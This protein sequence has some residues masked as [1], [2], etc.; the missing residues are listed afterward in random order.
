MFTRVTPY[1]P[2]KIIRVELKQ[3]RYVGGRN[4]REKYWDLS[5][6]ST[7]FRNV[8]LVTSL[9][10]SP[11]FLPNQLRPRVRTAAGA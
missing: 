6:L 9:E 4:S 3:S 2:L 1:H 11:F 8:P 10:V 5:R 7:L